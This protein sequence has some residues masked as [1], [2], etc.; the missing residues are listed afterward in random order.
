MN[1]L[2]PNYK[3]LMILGDLRWEDV[4]LQMALFGETAFFDPSHMVLSDITAP[5]IGFSTWS[6][7]A[8]ASDGR[9]GTDPA[10]FTELTDPNTVHKAVI[11]GGDSDT[12][13]AWIDTIAGFPFVPV[14]GD[15]T[16]APG[17][18]WGA[19]FAL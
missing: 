8:W 10:E 5:Q 11:Y 3:T 17:G 9:A 2:Y 4:D 18:V 19:W 7:N 1:Q 14:G 13:L 6:D 16:I 15:Y 12:L